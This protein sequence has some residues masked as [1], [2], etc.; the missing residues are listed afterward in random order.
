MCWS[1]KGRRGNSLNLFNIAR[2]CKAW[3]PGTLV[4][5]MF[6]TAAKGLTV[7]DVWEV[8]VESQFCDL[9]L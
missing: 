6:Q 5:V 8:G 2:L 9:V 1:F 7:E 4:M 3:W